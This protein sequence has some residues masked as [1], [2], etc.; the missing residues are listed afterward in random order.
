MEIDFVNYDPNADSKDGV[1]AMYAM[2]N[3]HKIRAEVRA[4]PPTHSDH[5]W[6]TF[7]DRFNHVR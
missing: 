6:I 4:Y 7:P 2:F 5:L 3:E 1:N